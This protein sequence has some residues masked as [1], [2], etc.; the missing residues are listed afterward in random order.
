[1]IKLQTIKCT[2]LGTIIIVCD[3]LFVTMSS[4][5]AEPV[6]DKTKEVESNAADSG[7]VLPLYAVVN[8]KKKRK[9]DVAPYVKKCPDDNTNSGI[10]NIVIPSKDEA[11]PPIAMEATKDIKDKPITI[12]SNSYGGDWW[13][14]YISEKKLFLVFVIAVILFHCV[15]LLSVCIAITEI[16]KL[17]SEAH[18]IKMELNESISSVSLDLNQDFTELSQ[19]LKEIITLELS[20]NIS[21][22]LFQ[23]QS[24][25]LP[26]SSCADI[27]LVNPSSLSG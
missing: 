26:A 25:V 19:E 20:Q 11:V 8:K 15:T 17:K 24:Q 1:M 7:L 16:S 4:L 21:A 27:L 18:Q 10:G 6:V 23:Q 12:N 3:S 14:K 22:Y 2:H 9:P 5:Y 13:R